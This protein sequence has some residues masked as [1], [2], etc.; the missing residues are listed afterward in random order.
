V[1][2]ADGVALLVDSGVQLVQEVRA[3]RTGGLASLRGVL[4][5][6]ATTGCV[7]TETLLAGAAIKAMGVVQTR[8]VVAGAVAV[9]RASIV[10]TTADW[11]VGESTSGAASRAVG[12]TTGDGVGTVA[13]GVASGVASGAAEVVTSRDGVSRAVTGGGRVRVGVK[14]TTTGK[15]RSTGSMLSTVVFKK[16]SGYTLSK[17]KGKLLLTKITVDAGV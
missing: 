7:S 9:C 3:V 15:L 8:R 6:A 1:L 13:G 4:I 12:I 2:V 14:G 11:V 17:L 5:V 16:M 10:V